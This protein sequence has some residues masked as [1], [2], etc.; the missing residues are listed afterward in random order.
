MQSLTKR[1]SSLSSLLLG[2]LA[3]G[4][5]A[6]PKEMEVVSN[7]VTAE[8]SMHLR[9]SPDG[10]ATNLIGAFVR[11]D[12]PSGGIDESSLARTRCSN[13]IKAKQIPAS[14]SFQELAQSSAGA[15]AKL[16]IKK[17]L[18]LSV[19]GA[20]SGLVLVRYKQ[21]G[22]LEADVD[23]DGLA[24]CC[25]T[26][27]E[28]CT[29]R[30][31][32]S[33]VL[34]DG[35][36]YALSEG[37]SGVNVDSALLSR[38]A[39]NVPIDAEVIASGSDKWERQSTFQ[40]QYFAFSLRAFGTGPAGGAGQS[41]IGTAP[42]APADDC[43]WTRTVPNDLDGIYFVGV[44][45]PYPTERLARDDAMRDA[46]EQV[47]RYLGEFLTEES[48]S[49]QL[50]SGKAES[51]EVLI[52]DDKVKSAINGGVARAVKDRKWCGPETLPTPSGEKQTMKV[53]AYYPNS[54]RKNASITALRLMIEKVKAR[55]GDTAGLEQMMK[56]VEAE[57]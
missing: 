42:A 25:A 22:K 2:V 33:A 54:E 1:P 5:C 19:G 45:N 29:G 11:N 43:S 31:V 53:L 50:T 52:N 55:N 4:S 44:S 51:L 23:E 30:Y 57:K 28:E 27:P 8:P 56:T 38:L 40:R 14:G 34:A 35:S 16:G 39:D 17:L 13:F 46:R 48:G 21:L 7:G 49:V 9:A 37:S 32:A 3:F 47:V 18:S 15:K 26:A 20:Q 12:A 6:T 36:H 24:R 41:T 10:D